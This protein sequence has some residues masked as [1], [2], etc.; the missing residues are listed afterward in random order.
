MM[1]RYL[2]AGLL[3][4]VPLGVTLLVLNVLVNLMDRSLLLLP[5][6]LRPDT[7]LGFHIPG[8]GIVLTVVVVVLTGM[9]VANFFG[10][11]LVSAWEAVLARIPLVRSIYNAVKQVVETLLSSNGKSFRKALLIQYP[12]N[13]IWTIGFQTGETASEVKAKTG[14]DLIN[15]F[16]PT[17]PNPTSGFVILVPR[18]DVVELDMSVDDALKMIISMGVV[19]PRENNAVA[20]RKPAGPAGGVARGAPG[21]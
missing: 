21:P 17:T 1:R 19:T 4:W 9:I 15:I 5:A 6:A 20:G 10:R 2:I 13:G 12:R 16:V 3:V 7:L 8:L 18:Q 14:Y 11:R